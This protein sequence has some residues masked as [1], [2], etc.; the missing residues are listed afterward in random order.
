M[1][2]VLPVPRIA[3]P[4]DYPVRRVVYDLDQ[5]SLVSESLIDGRIQPRSCTRGDHQNSLWI[6]LLCNGSLFVLLFATTTA[7]LPLDTTGTGAHASDGSS[8]LSSSKLD[9]LLDF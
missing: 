7:H 2:V 6:G 8:D 5:V 3:V 1:R 4:S 9:T